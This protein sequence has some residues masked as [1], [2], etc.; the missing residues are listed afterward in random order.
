MA[1]KP[2]FPN[3]VSF[4]VSSRLEANWKFASWRKERR[5]KKVAVIITIKLENAISLEDMKKDLKYEE[6]GMEFLWKFM[7]KTYENIWKIRSPAGKEN[8]YWLP[9]HKPLA[10]MFIRQ[11]EYKPKANSWKYRLLTH[12]SQLRYLSFTKLAGGFKHFKTSF[13]WVF[14]MATEGTLFC[15]CT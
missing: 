13:A 1:H 2:C 11:K 4:R 7:D 6:Y 12:S 9:D 10:K 8:E 15:N 14:C 5:P 3:M